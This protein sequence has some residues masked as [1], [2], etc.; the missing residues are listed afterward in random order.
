[1]A[2]KAPSDESRAEVNRLY[3]VVAFGCNQGAHELLRDVFLRAEDPV[4]SFQFVEY[5]YQEPIR[6]PAKRRITD[7]DIEAALATVAFFPFIGRVLEADRFLWLRNLNPAA[8]AWNPAGPST[9][10]LVPATKTTITAAH[11][12]VSF[13]PLSGSEIGKRAVYLWLTEGNVVRHYAVRTRADPAEIHAK[14]YPLGHDEYDTTRWDTYA[15]SVSNNPVLAKEFDLLFG[16][17][18]VASGA[19]SRIIVWGYPIASKNVMYGHLLLVWP[20]PK[21]DPAWLGDLHNCVEAGVRYLA[22]SSYQ[23][24]LA[25]LYNS[26]QEKQLKKLAA[27]A[28]TTSFDGS[29]QKEALKLLERAKNLWTDCDEDIERGLG[30]LWDRRFAL[31]QN[32]M[33]ADQ[34]LKD[35]KIDKKKREAEKRRTGKDLDHTLLFSKYNMASPGMI[36]ELRKVMKQAPRL[37]RP[38]K[39]GDALPCALVYGEPGS[40]KDTLAKLIPLFT[41]GHDRGY[42]GM[43]P[44]AINMAA[45][46]PSALIGPVLLGIDLPSGDP[47]N[48]EGLLLSGSGRGKKTK[49][50]LKEY[51]SNPQVFILDELNSVDVDFQGILLRILEN[52]EVM[53]L[54]GPTTEHVRHLI[55]GVVNEDPER[56][57]REFETRSV[58]QMQV[59]FG[60]MLGS[61]LYEALTK[62]RR[63]RPDLFYRL[64]REVYVRLPSLRDRPE[65]IPI[66]FYVECNQTF[67]DLVANDPFLKDRG[68]FLHVELPAFAVLMSREWDWP[69]NIRQLQAVARAVA[70]DAYDELRNGRQRTDQKEIVV[71]TARVRKELAI[72]FGSD[73]LAGTSGEGGAR[74]P[75]ETGPRHS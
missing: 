23:P 70:G 36:G 29:K 13:S 22:S 57:T 15:A 19:G 64:K 33:T 32:W 16:F 59:F 56:L 40:G 51:Q 65:D 53:P 66:L 25:L 47:R 28:G 44:R 54:F 18:Q 67:S 50:N 58:E 27:S 9:P 8:A 7:S 55:I 4:H 69:G 45:I 60:R 1:M 35:R 72:V 62:G 30:A 74:E 12:T 49:E 3:E 75:G 31:A 5:F 63:L 6:R 34:K 42:F 24:T 2:K 61:V 17:W 46:K 71:Q 68:F 26:L 52:G 20:I 43:D 41:E 14:Y 11:S 73:R 38:E 48:L 39:N 10:R 37:K 21:S